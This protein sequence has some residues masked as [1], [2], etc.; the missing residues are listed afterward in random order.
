MDATTVLDGKVDLDS[1]EMVPSNF[2]AEEFGDAGAVLREMHGFALGDFAE[3][4]TNRDDIVADDQPITQETVWEMKGPGAPGAID[5]GRRLA[6]MDEMRVDRQ[7]V[8]PSYGLCGMMFLFMPH[9]SLLFG[10]DP[11]E[12]DRFALG[13]QII[14][15]HNAWAARVT[16]SFDA[17]RMRAVGILQPQPETLEQLM[18]DTE[19]AL[20]DGI[21]AFWLSGSQPLAGMSPGNAELDPF[22]KLVADAEAAVTLHIGTEQALVQPLP[23]LMGIPAFQ[24]A[25]NSSLEFPVQ[26]FSSSILHFPPDL[27]LT[28]MIL[29]GVFERHPNLR[30]GVIECAA[31]WVGPMAERLDMWAEEFSKRFND[32][33]LRPSEYLARNVRVT[34]F[35]FEPV[36]YYLERY[37]EMATVYAYSS[38]YPHREGGKHSDR[39]FYE[40][41]KGFDAETQERFFHSN[42]EWLVPA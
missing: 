10:F 12:V 24:P 28:S 17:T 8:Y 25:H 37:P 5:F 42:G 27:F 39:T 36:D 23:W 1:H 26:P 30:F 15:E 22:W 34:P 38:D 4:T 20:S 16:R 11:E 40:R 35:H 2:W 9:A 41:L 7:L 19:Q 32:L 6:V 18:L 14:R 13:S 21:R 3:N 33:S 29:G 31:Q